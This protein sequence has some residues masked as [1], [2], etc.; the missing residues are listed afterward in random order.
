MVNKILS[1][2]FEYVIMT[3]DRKSIV[4]GSKKWKQIID[5]NKKDRKGIV[6]YRTKGAAKNVIKNSTFYGK[7]LDGNYLNKFT[8]KNEDFLEVVEIKTTL[9]LT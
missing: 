8:S 9:T 7:K 1:E 4:K 3:R 5:I 2:T 6:I